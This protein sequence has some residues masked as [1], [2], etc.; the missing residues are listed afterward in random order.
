VE[1]GEA[2][3]EHADALLDSA[4]A[5]RLHED[6]CVVVDHV[7]GNQL[8]QLVESAVVY[9]VKEPLRDRLVLLEAHVLLFLS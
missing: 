5:L 1:V 4:W 8:G 2:L 3:Q 6:H 7:R 9:G